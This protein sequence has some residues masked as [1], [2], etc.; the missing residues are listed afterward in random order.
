MKAMIMDGFG[1]IAD[2]RWTEIPTPTPAPGEV[3]IRIHAAGVNP[4]DWK[5]M[6][7]GMARLFPCEFPLIPGW[8]AAGTVAALGDGVEGFSI[9][10]KVWTFARKPSIQW[11][12]YADYVAMDAKAVAPMP[13]C[14]SYAQASTIPLAG[15]TAWQ[16]LFDMA[17]IRPGHSVLIHA[18]AGG[19]GSLAIPL[20]K[21]AGA[22]VITTA[23]PANHDYV[24]A[25]GADHVIDYA[26]ADFVAETRRL[27]P[28]GVDMA[29]ATLGGESLERSYDV[30][31]AGGILVSISG[32]TDKERAESLGIRVKFLFVQPDGGQLRRLAGLVDQG[33]LAAPEIAEFPV[34]DAAR[35]LEQSREGHVR[36]KLVLVMA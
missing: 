23:S 36:G 9:G 7:G 28:D 34:T 22:T 18:G 17:R 12:T 4:V 33:I 35:A 2:L 21:W 30:V 26:A 32:R 31:K 1:P 16:S 5:I 15:L 24:R 8:D 25:L 29:Y 13:R 3:L 10:Q 11:G 6:E 19:V 14:L 27:F 20:A